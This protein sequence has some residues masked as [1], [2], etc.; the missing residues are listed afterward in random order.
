MST[1]PSQAK[2]PKTSK[3]PKSG[4]G[5]LSNGMASNPLEAYIGGQSVPARE[6][7]VRTGD[8]LTAFFRKYIRG[9]TTGADQG[10]TGPMIGRLLCSLG[11]I[12]VA[13]PI[14]KTVIDA[15]TALSELPHH[16]DLADA[17]AVMEIVKPLPTRQEFWRMIG[18]MRNESKAANG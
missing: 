12:N 1:Q 13:N 16:Q 4:Q 6:Q 5:V 7:E 10:W 15:G 17:G 2:A 9:A 8:R 3:A 14:T 18:A 11:Y